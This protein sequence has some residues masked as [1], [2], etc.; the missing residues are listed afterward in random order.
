MK[1]S[2]IKRRFGEEG[3]RNLDVNNLNGKALIS[4]DTQMTLFTADGMV[5]S[6]KKF[7]GRGIGSY[8]S[9]GVYKS[10]LRWYYTQVNINNE[11]KEKFFMENQEHEKDFSILDYKELYV[12][13]A[14]GLTCLSELKSGVMGTIIMK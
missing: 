12:R 9:S 8:A 2:E 7:S 10:Y 1:L 5:W 14:P 3:I 4:D 6:Y 13:M 11:D